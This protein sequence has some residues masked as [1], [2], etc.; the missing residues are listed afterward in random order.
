MRLQVSK[1][2][3]AASFYVVKSVYEN[4]RHSSR[5]VEKLGTYNDLLEKLGGRDPYEWAEEY[6]RELNRK[7]KEGIQPEVIAKYSPARQIEKGVRQSYHGGYLFLRRMFHEL[8]LHKICEEIG[9][10]N[11]SEFSLQD[12]LSSLLYT[13]ILFPG[14]KKSTHELS[15]SF[16]EGPAFELHQV[17]RALD[18]INKESDFIQAELY[19]NSAKKAG[20]NT[21]VLYYDCTNYFFETE[22]ESGLRQYGISKEHRPNP[23]VQMGLFMDGDGIP[24]AFSIQKGNTNEQLTLKPLEKKILSDF[25]LSRFVVCTDAGLGSVSNREFNGRGERA[26]IVTQS[27]K[28]LKG[29]V[30]EWALEP[31]G[32]RLSGERRA[33]DLGEIDE[34]KH[35]DSVFYK[36]QW[37]EIKGLRQRMLVSY[38]V[39]HRDYQ[40]SIR[41]RQIS[42]ALEAIQSGKGVLSHTSQNDYKR[43]IT[44]THSTAEGEVADQTIFGLNEEAIGREAMYDGFYAICTSLTDEAAEIIRINKQRWEIEE[45]F[46]IMK[47]E[48]KARPV[49]LSRDERIQAHFMTCFLSLVLYR[50]LEKRLGKRFTCEDTIGQLRKMDFQYIKGSGYVP[51]YTRTDFTDALHEAFG[52]RTDY[53]IVTHKQMKE[54]IKMTKMK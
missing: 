52:F 48:F 2:K 25:E 49:Y 40:R 42:R 31:Q 4:K 17:Y 43:L 14:S 21:G 28:Q 36:E 35:R 33:Y 1:T 9:K 23:I 16:L 3:N 15:R 22:E 18:I 26:F 32:W 7:E 11:K 24:L 45:C 46:R 37:V 13:R 5:V 38:S 41:D 54:I 39:K 30:R 20:R 12:I 29:P 10:R 8:G 27:L 6:V 47:S 19:K 34:E 51:C 44:R 50:M 53:E